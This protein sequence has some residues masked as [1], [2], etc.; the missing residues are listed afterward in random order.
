MAH[1]TLRKALRFKKQIEAALR[2]SGAPVSI[3]IDID[4]PAVTDI[5]SYLADEA[6]K[7]VEGVERHTRLSLILSD[8]RSKIEAANAK[9]VNAILSQIGHIDRQIAAY[10]PFADAKPVQPDLL[11]VKLARKQEAS[12]NPVAQSHGYGHRHDDGSTLKV[13]PLT[14]D[15]I[16]AYKA[17]LVAL[18][19]DKENL[20]DQ[21]LALNNRDDLSVEIG[22][23]DLKFLSELEII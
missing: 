16:S 14:Q 23:D 13:C 17:K 2:T 11:K 8:V 21:R 6:K 18:R 19:K 22:D 15:T 4:D 10:K 12:K 7:L 1:I 5:G 20:E 3:A 9:G